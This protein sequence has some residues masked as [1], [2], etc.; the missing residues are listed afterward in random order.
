MV[1]EK[2]QEFYRAVETRDPRYDGRFFY[3]VR[4]T[5]VYCRPVCGSR[6]PLAEN[7]QFFS[8]A[9][10]AERASYRPCKRCKPKESHAPVDERF[11]RAAREIEGSEEPP[12]LHELA[13]IAGMS[14]FHFQRR[15]KAALGVSP[16]QYADMVK[17]NRLRRALQSGHSVTGAIFEAGFGSLSQAYAKGRSPLGMTASQFRSRGTNASVS[18][19]IVGSPIGRILIAATT[20]GICRVDI[21]ENDELLERRLFEELSN[22][23]V[24]REDEALESAVSLIVAYLSGAGPWPALPLDV[25]ATAFQSRVW[26][27]LRA[28][29][30]GS[31]VTYS[32]LAQAIGSPGAARA[33]ASACAANP[34]ALLIPCHRVIPKSGGAGAYRWSV[35]RKRHLL[36]L[37]NVKPVIS[38]SGATESGPG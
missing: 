24:R 16:R 31:K 10:A 27:A 38:S 12:A 36:E 22:A 8:S 20:R 9:E 1:T 23:L 33:V 5:G 15:F 14:E 6:T 17:R 21:G 29:R 30:P 25:R 2:I 13:R 28:V 34:V 11:L 3:G 19:A 32:Q 7:V 4:T 35:E 18:Y 37:E 26:E